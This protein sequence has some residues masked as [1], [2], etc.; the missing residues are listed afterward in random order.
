MDQK[1]ISGKRKEREKRKPVSEVAEQSPAKRQKGTIQKLKKSDVVDNA[2]VKISVEAKK[3]DAE[4]QVTKTQGEKDRET[5]DPS[6]EKPKHY[7]DQ[8]TA[9]ISN[10]SFQACCTLQPLILYVNSCTSYSEKTETFS[11]RL[12]LI[13]GMRTCAGNL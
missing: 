2:Q 12:V 1:E 7:N 9:F 4:V 10:L 5:K 6:H 11:V 3:E 13:C 8:C